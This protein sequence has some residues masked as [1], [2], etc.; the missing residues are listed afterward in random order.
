MLPR[1][2]E[3]DQDYACYQIFINRSPFF[4]YLDTVLQDVSMG[5]LFFICVN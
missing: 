5:T 1:V 3:F 2:F 4:I